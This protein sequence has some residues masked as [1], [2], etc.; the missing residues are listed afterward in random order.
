V[1]ENGLVPD[2]IKASQ[3]LIPAQDGSVIQ[4][5]IQTYADLGD[6]VGANL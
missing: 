1:A 5:L 3:I 2:L 6:P 4:A